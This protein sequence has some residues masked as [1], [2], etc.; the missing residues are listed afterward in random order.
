VAGVIPGGRGVVNVTKLAG[1]ARGL[2][3]VART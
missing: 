3:P 2:A 1:A